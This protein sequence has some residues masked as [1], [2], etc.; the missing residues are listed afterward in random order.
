MQGELTIT[1]STLTGNVALGG[2]DLVTDPAKGIAGAVFN[3]NGAFTA[4]GSTF[5]RNTAADYAS[6]IFNLVADEA[7]ARTAQV[8]LRDTIVANGQGGSNQST[9]PNFT[10]SDVTSDETNYP[11][12]NKVGAS[13]T[14]DES[15]FDLVTAS[16]TM[17]LGTLTGTPR[18]ADPLLGPL[19]NNGGPTATLL[20]QPGSPAIDAGAA[21]GLTTDQR[22]LLRPFDFPGVPDPAGG[23]GS[24]IGA[25]ELQPACN[26]EKAPG[27][28][29]PA[30]AP[31]PGGT[32]PGSTPG[33]G[34]GATVTPTIV[35]VHQSGAVWVEG[36]RLPHASSKRRHPV[37]TVFSFTLNETA[38]VRFTFAR[39]VSGRKVGR[40]C[41]AETKRNR[42][43]QRCTRLVAAG[44]LAFTGHTGP[45]QLAFQGRLSA[46]S[47][48]KLG[49]YT[50]TIVATSPLG[51][52]STPRT[53]RFQIV[54]R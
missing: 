48:L 6:Q 49:G 37:G 7:T 16:H 10:T 29:C 20:P 23:D 2:A 25:V 46:A 50:L 11:G 4:I 33:G 15:A 9:V 44:S 14:V 41:V 35:G 5:A 36:S 51:Q 42:H 53:L 34:I 24:D 22:G 3:L 45:N 8:A 32:P 30:P 17:E 28:G 39:V 21:F 18:T 40:N 1:D 47:K 38:S 12:P 52:K 26:G 54:S 13:A 31:P 43:N 19:A 27:L